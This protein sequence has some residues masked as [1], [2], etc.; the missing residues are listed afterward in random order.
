M[1]SFTA[2]V[3]RNGIWEPVLAQ[4]GNIRTES[5]ATTLLEELQLVNA[6]QNISL[7]ELLIFDES[8]N[9]SG[10]SLGTDYLIQED[11]RKEVTYP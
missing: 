3:K 2:V 7:N 11:L 10:G 9:I 8:N 5:N 4:D 6:D 1:A